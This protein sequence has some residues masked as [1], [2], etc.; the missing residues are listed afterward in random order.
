M[1]KHHTTTNNC[2][3]TERKD[4]RTFRPTEWRAA[5]DLQPLANILRPKGDRDTRKNSRREKGHVEVDDRK[6]G[7]YL[8]MQFSGSGSV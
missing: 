2:N 1:Y 8:A 5:S 3:A 7:Y 4:K 6:V